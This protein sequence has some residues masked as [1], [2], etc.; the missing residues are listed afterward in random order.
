M[1]KKKKKGGKNRSAPSHRSV[2]KKVVAEWRKEI[3]ASLKPWFLAANV[4]TELEPALR[5]N[6]RQLLAK[7]NEFTAADRRHSLRVARDCAKICK[8][9][10]PK[11]FPKRVSLDTF[12]TVLDLA[13]T[14]HKVCQGV[15]GSGGW[16]DIGG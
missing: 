10:Q 12:E 13:A 6:I 5:E 2:A 3:K 14:Q 9:L 1:A 16:C 8:I 4:F 7:G 11:P 15:G